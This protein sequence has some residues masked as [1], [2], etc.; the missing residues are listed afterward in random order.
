MNEF[1]EEQFDDD[2]KMRILGVVSIILTLCSAIFIGVYLYTTM[3]QKT[4]EIEQQQV[5]I[6]LVETTATTA[7]FEEST[8]VSQK[9][10]E[11]TTT[12]PTEAKDVL[13]DV[14]FE[15]P[16]NGACGYAL[17]EMEVYDRNMGVIG[18]LKA[19]QAFVI[20]GETL[21]LLIIDYGG[22]TGYVL[23]S[24]SMINL[25]DV[26]PSIIYDNAN[27]YASILKSGEFDIPGLTGEKLY[28][29]YYENARLGYKEYVMPCLYYTAE[30]I[31]KV[32]KNCLAQG[33]CLYLVEA[34]RPYPTECTIRTTF[35]TLLETN[36]MAAMGVSNGTW[37]IS[38]F[39]SMY[40]SNHQRGCAVDVSLVKVTD[41][42]SQTIAGVEVPKVN[43][44]EEYE[45]QCPLHDMSLAAVLFT[46]PVASQDPK[47]WKSAIYA[48]NVTEATKKLHSYFA[49]EGMS[50]LASE[51]W[52][53][54]DLEAKSFLDQNAMYG[55]YYLE[56]NCSRLPE[57][58]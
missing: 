37:G 10:Q 11:E 57:I 29:T 8:E 22:E 21:D 1:D 40:L 38:W 23:K 50:P 46:A 6:M 30:K 53:F 3:Q 36:P 35:S 28:E 55:N 9:A 5:S 34:F 56:E 48:D 42:G 39:V 13:A 49:D 19:G 12:Q 17:G 25:P 20:Q 24:L 47:A 45:M 32:Q 27:S 41:L 51:W 15:L 4:Q 2:S 43:A 52:H 26:I 33:D 58:Q 54:N 16:I 44:Y 7:S 31:A 18:T 14:V